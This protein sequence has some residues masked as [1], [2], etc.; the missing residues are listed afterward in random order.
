[1]AIGIKYYGAGSRPR[2]A[3]PAMGPRV[4]SFEETDFIGDPSSTGIDDSDD[5]SDSSVNAANRLAFDK[6]KFGFD[7][8]K[9][10]DTKAKTRADQSFESR[11]FEAEQNAALEALRR[12][13]TGA[14]NQE[15]YLRT[16]LAQGVSPE[17]LSEIT[18]QETTG[19]DYVNKQAEELIK[20]LTTARDT[21]Q[22][23]Q[24]AGFDRLKQFLIDNPAQAYALAQRAAPTVQSNALAQYMQGQ[25]VDPSM[26]QSA[27]DEANA[28]SLGGATNYNQLLNVLTGAEASGQSSRQAEEQMSRTLQDAQLQAIFGAGRAGVEG[29]QARGLNELATQISNARIGATTNQA[30]QNQA[31]Q[32]ALATI[33]GTGLVSP[34]GTAVV[35]ETVTETPA[36][37]RTPIEILREQVANTTDT[38]L[39]AKVDA[40]IRKNPTASLA[41]IERVFPKL[42]AA[43][44]NR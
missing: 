15:A 13:Q 12:T 21:S 16:L 14:K 2:S 41:A 18:K 17:I 36:V 20:R 37:T 3:S 19:R 26:A 23:T 1:M 9:Y 44:R 25:G 11:K 22:T 40:Y 7:R 43:Q 35:E 24:T 39:K 30:A 32:N 31:V 29:E 33:Y 5:P 42:A 4:L 10:E 28:Q 34:P 27:V 6:T 38:K 8:K